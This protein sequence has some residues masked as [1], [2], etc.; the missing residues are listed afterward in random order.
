MLSLASLRHS[1]ARSPATALLARSLSTSESLKVSSASTSPPPA[2]EERIKYFKIY[3]WDP[4]HRQKPVR[5][6]RP[7]RGL[8]AAPVMFAVFD[9]SLWS[10]PAPFVL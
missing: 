4:D 1:V 6:Q 9:V 7:F 5:A 10:W 3:R 8:S 2:E